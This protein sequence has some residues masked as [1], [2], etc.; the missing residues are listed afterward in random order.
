MNQRLG[1][2]LA[3]IALSVVAKIPSASAEPPAQIRQVQLMPDVPAPFLVQ[4]WKQ[5]ATGLDQL[6]FNLS[7]KGQ[8]LPLL[9]LLHDQNQ[10]VVGFGIPDYVGDLREPDG[11]G[12]GIT[13]MGAVWGATL[14][15]IDKSKGNPDYVNLCTD[16]FDSRPSYQMFGNKIHA[17]D[18]E[19]TFWY[20]IF[21][22]IILSSIAERYPSEQS[23]NAMAHQAADSWAK[24]TAA[25][26]DPAKNDAA[27]YDHTGFN[28]DTMQPVDNGHWKEPDAGAGVAWLEYAGFN[29]WHD[30]A[31]LKAADEC[32]RYL[33]QRPADQGPWYEVLMPFGALTAIRMN[34]EQGRHYDTSKMINWCFDLSAA[35]PDW[36]VNTDHWENVDAA[37][38]V[39]GTDRCA[40]R[41]NKVGGYGFAMNTFCWAWPLVPIA[42]YDARYAHDIG[43]WMLN[44]ASAARLYY[45]QYHPADR[46]TSADWKGDPNHFIAYEGLKYRWDDPNQPLLATG[47]PLHEHWGPHT[48]YG[49]YG[50]VF[51]GVYGAIISQTNVPQILRLD[52]LATDSCHPGAYPS[53]LYFNPLRTGQNISLD[54]GA[55]PCDLYDAVSGSFLNRHCIG[56]TSINIPAGGAR[57]IV[58]TPSDGTLSYK[59]GKTY[60]NDI[61][62]DYRRGTESK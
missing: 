58:L 28:F 47:D 29:R 49:L 52:L 34:A 57:V 36:K 42:R 54:V 48:D 60:V 11:R 27:N 18:P 53:F 41:G 38:L 40:E 51:V 43:K 55:K 1:A 62:I 35:R 32:M 24:A 8:Y 14:I 31:F 7:A 3:G 12:S 19:K 45:S 61:V 56:S 50:S 4:D 5:V 6:L 23:I 15:G 21:P 9:H 22:N 16:F 33:D 39:G 59:N 46:Q 10:N 2:L 44:A 25:L 13:C 17:A 26:A 30:P 20:T 37:G